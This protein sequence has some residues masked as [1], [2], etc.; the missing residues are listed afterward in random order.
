[1]KSI[2][3]VRLKIKFETC[4]TQRKNI[5]ITAKSSQKRIQN[6]AKPVLVSQ[7]NDKILQANDKSMFQNT[8]VY[9]CGLCV[10]MLTIYNFPLLP[11]FI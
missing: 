3:I 9:I 5:K 8:P 11:I 2:I 7:I 6:K 4:E 10:F 1:M